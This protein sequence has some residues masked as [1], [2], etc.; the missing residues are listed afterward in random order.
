MRRK[1]RAASGAGNKKTE[2][3]IPAQVIEKMVDLARLELAT[4]SLR[5]MRSPI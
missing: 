4:S 1:R 5:T 2:Q 3:E